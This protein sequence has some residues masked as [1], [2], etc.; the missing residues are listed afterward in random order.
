MA[1]HQFVQFFNN[2][3]LVHKLAVRRIAKYLSITSIC[4]DLIDVKWRLSTHGVVYKHDKE[5]VIEC[6]VY[7]NFSGGWAQADSNNAENFMSRT[8]YV[9]MSAEFPLL[10]YSK[11]QT[12]VASITTEAGYI[13]LIELMHNVIPFMVIIK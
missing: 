8:L 4:V 11:L 5:K 7:A 1:V 10:W 2:L 12:E 9:I 6:Y 3:C 13:S